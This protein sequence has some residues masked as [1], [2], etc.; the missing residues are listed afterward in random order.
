[1]SAVSSYFP[2]ISDAV[3]YIVCGTVIQEVKTS[4]VAKEVDIHVFLY[5]FSI[6]NLTILKLYDLRSVCFGI[7]VF[8][9]LFLFS[10]LHL[11]LDCLTAFPLTQ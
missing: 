2:I 7:E 6:H 1:M 5:W 10:R 4:N 9:Q 11:V 3:D 8:S